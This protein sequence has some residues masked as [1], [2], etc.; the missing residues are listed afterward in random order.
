[1]KPVGSRAAPKKP[2]EKDEV[3]AP[4]ETD[5]LKSLDTDFPPLDAEAPE[6]ATEV[7]SS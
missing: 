5:L 7:A 4:P 1:M 3:L 2:W 6:A